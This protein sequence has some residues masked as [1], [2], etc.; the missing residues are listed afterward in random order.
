MHAVTAPG[1]ISGLKL[2]V[3]Q[4]VCYTEKVTEARH[5]QD[6]QQQ[7]HKHNYQQPNHAATE[8]STNK[9]K[10]EDGVHR[11]AT[12]IHVWEPRRNFWPDYDG[13]LVNLGKGPFLTDVAMHNLSEAGYSATADANGCAALY[14]SATHAVRLLFASTVYE[15]GPNATLVP[16]GSGNATAA[17]AMFSLHSGDEKS[18]HDDSPDMIVGIADVD[19]DSVVDVCVKA[20]SDEAQVDS[21]LISCMATNSSAAELLSAADAGCTSPIVRDFIPL[22]HEM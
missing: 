2:G 19:G 14:P 4:T 9:T 3:L 7:R 12:Y 8:Q 6:R 13:E 22:C 5:C 15:H 21:V 17:A 1:S 18:G 20:A 10:T 11:Q 16:F